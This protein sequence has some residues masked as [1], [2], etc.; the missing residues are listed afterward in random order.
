MA[1]NEPRL[2]MHSTLSMPLFSDPSSPAIARSR[3]VASVESW[4]SERLTTTLSLLVS[5]VVTNAVLHGGVNICLELSVLRSHAVRV[6]V[7][8]SSSELPELQSTTSLERESG[9]GLQLVDALADTWGARPRGDGKVVWFELSH[10]DG[11]PP[12]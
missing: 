4:A 11:D 10:T 8:D 5:E 9:R 6:E 7:F 3:A 12:A 1:H 2:V